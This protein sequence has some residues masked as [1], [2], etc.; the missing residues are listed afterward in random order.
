M[1][2]P[3]NE[4]SNIVED[5]HPSEVV[6]EVVYEETEKIQEEPKDEAFKPIKEKVKLSMHACFYCKVYEGSK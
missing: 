4:A 2:T 6:E 5:V 3:I 1:D